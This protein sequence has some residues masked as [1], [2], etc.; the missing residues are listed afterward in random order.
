MRSKK[1]KTNSAVKQPSVRVNLAAKQKLDQIQA[2]TDLSQPALLDRAIDLL[3]L[4]MRAKQFSQDMADLVGQ[5]KVLREY[6]KIAAAFDG[7]SAD[8]LDKK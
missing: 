7:A 3:Q 4:E 2:E 5:P 8:G 6:H 1:M